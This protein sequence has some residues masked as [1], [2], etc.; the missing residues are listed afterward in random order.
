MDGR[1]CEGRIDIAGAKNSALRL[2]AAS[3]L[4]S[5]TVRL[6]NYP[7]ALLDAQIHVGML[8]VLGK[9]ASYVGRAEVELSQSLASPFQ[10]IFS[11]MAP[12]GP[13]SA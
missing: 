3:L 6:T 10:P 8:E 13:N 5:R 1:P 4:T 11:I 12:G 2:L 7:A 9:K